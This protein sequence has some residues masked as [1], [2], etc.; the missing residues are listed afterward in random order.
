MLAQ[1]TKDFKLE[2]THAETWSKA[3][4]WD[5]SDVESGDDDESRHVHRTPSWRSEELSTIIRTMNEHEDVQIL[6]GEPS[7]R[8]KPTKTPKKMAE[9]D[10]SGDEDLLREEQ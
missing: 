7:S 2:G 9:S 3:T 1:R 6:Y 10:T 5:M 4:A 8:K